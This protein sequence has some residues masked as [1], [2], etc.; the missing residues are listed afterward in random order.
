[1]RQARQTKGMNKYNGVKMKKSQVMREYYSISNLSEY[2]G[3]SGR[4]LRDLLHCPSNPIPHYR[5]G[6]TGRILRIKKAEF[7]DWM[8]SQRATNENGIDALLESVMK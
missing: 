7:D 2:T 3:I 1:M 5:I 8:M 6:S 4:T